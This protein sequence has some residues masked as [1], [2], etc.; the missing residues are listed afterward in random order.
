MGIT[1]L[2]LLL[3]MDNKEQLEEPGEFLWGKTR[4]TR[5]YLSATS[6]ITLEGGWEEEGRQHFIR[7]VTTQV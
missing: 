7:A 2:V 6:V 3:W 5:L 1:Q 4:K